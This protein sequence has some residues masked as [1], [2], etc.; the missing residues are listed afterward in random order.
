[1]A[2]NHSVKKAADRKM[3]DRKMIGVSLH[4]LAGMTLF[5]RPTFFCHWLLFKPNKA[6]LSRLREGFAKARL[7]AKS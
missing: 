1:M 6:G 4:Q 3:E 2:Q 7:Y 5:F